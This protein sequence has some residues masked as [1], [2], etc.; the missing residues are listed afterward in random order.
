MIKLRENGRQNYKAFGFTLQTGREDEYRKNYTPKNILS[1]YAFGRYWYWDVPRILKPKQVWVNTNTF[2]DNI[3]GYH[4][5][6]MRRYSFMVFDDH[7]TIYYG[8]QPDN[9]LIGGKRNYKYIE[10]PWNQTR[11]VRY[12]FLYPTGKLFGSHDDEVRGRN[13]F[14]SIDK[15]RKEVPKVYFNFNDSDGEEIQ[16]ECYLEEMEWRYGVGLFKWLRYIRKPIIRRTLNIT[17]NKET[18]AR[19]GSWKGGTIGSSVDAIVG[20][21]A[22]HSFIRY[23]AEHG[24]NNVKQLPNEK[25]YYQ[26]IPVRKREPES[27]QCEA[28][29]N[30]NG[31]KK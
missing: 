1:I 15:L 12:D 9:M 10:F 23:A 21:P 26:N 24:F 27:G 31:N 11:R 6:I 19:K 2:V 13:W 29:A 7:A 30:N 3:N 5:Y 22:E 25:L 20:E 14:D 16:A 18:G 28:V 8:L 4:A 17:F